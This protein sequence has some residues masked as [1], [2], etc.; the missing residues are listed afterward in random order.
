MGLL[1]R[2]CLC[3][4]GNACRGW[5]CRAYVKTEAAVAACACRR[6]P[7][8]FPIIGGRAWNGSGQ[9]ARGCEPA[10]AQVGAKSPARCVSGAAPPAPSNASIL[11]LNDQIFRLMGLA[12][13]AIS[14][15]R[16]GRQRSLAR[17]QF[18]PTQPHVKNRNLLSP[19]R[20]DRRP[21]TSASS[22]E[23]PRSSAVQLSA[24]P[25]GLERLSLG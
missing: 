25:L 20:V 16:R 21:S 4:C 13:C 23:R 5:P 7:G 12:R 24:R 15:Q 9:G 2:Q 17:L 19:A 14:G 8:L 3:S 1:R 22:E 11:E 18:A 6:R 10:I